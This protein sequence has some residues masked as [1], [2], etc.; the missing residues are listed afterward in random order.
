MFG[1]FEGLHVKQLS[2]LEVNLDG[3]RYFYVG[4]IESIQP[5][6]ISYVD[7]PQVHL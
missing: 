1:T 6:K 7:N 2:E 3:I 5:P 4:R